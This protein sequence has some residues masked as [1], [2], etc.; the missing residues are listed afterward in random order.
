MPEKTRVTRRS[1]A[2]AGGAQVPACRADAAAVRR[3]VPFVALAA[4]VVGVLAAAA[5]Q[6][7]GAYPGSPWFQPG[8]PYDANFPDPSVFYD[9][10]TG[11]YY[12]YATNTGGAYV[13]AMS[14]ADAATWVARPA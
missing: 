3:F 6:P 8:M 11:R 7:A 2:E 4:T 12:A 10:A 5:P 1:Y 9:P 13:P 14:S